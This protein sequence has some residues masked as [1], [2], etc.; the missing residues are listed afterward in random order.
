VSKKEYNLKGDPSHGADRLRDLAIKLGWRDDKHIASVLSRATAFSVMKIPT[1]IF[2]LDWYTH[3]G[4]PI[5][6]VT[7]IYGRKDSCKTTTMLKILANS[8]R[9]CH[10]CHYPIVISPKNGDV[11]CNCPNPRYVPRDPK[12][13]Q[14]VDSAEDAKTILSGERLSFGKDSTSGY[15]AEIKG[16]KYFFDESYR[17]A[18]MRSLFVETEHKLDRRWADANGV[19]SD[20]VVVLSSDDSERL[21]DTVDSL[22]GS[23]ELDIVFIDTL[24]MLIPNTHLEKSF[25]DTPKVAAAAVLKQRFLQKVIATQ[26]AKGVYDDRPVTVVCNSQVRNKISRFGSSMGTSEC[27][28]LKHIACL[29][30]EFKAMGYTFQHMEYASYGEFMFTIKKN[31]AGGPSN[32]SGKWKMWLDPHSKDYAIGDTDDTKYIIQYGRE[33]NL[34]TDGS[35][36]KIKSRHLK[37]HKGFKT[38]DSLGKF[39]QDNPTVRA[40]VRH[41]VLEKLTTYR[42]LVKEDKNAKKK[43]S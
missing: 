15:S 34:I 14:F 10:Y 20:L 38:L 43:K 31:H 27:E 36:Y 37:G 23:G 28:A 22:L 6:R 42:T 25:A 16:K 3:G 4:I 41:N 39:L 9:Y 32:V 12:C 30:I 24:S 5:D 11:N 33:V 1:G 18:P 26:N 35:T 40:E 17:C 8:Q 13:L 21:L 7:R 2:M 29:D 19:N